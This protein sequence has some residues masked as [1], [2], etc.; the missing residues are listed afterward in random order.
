[1]ICGSSSIRVRRMIRPTRV[2][3]GSFLSAQTAPVPRSA[4]ARIERNA[5]FKH[6]EVVF[7]TKLYKSR[8]EAAIVGR[9]V[10]ASD[11]PIVLK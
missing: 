2:T 11:V 3:R 6:L 5:A 7:G 1:M 4:S 8:L 10:A 9:V